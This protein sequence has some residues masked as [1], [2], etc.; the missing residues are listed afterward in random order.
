M[1]EQDRPGIVVKRYGGS[2]LYD[3]AAARYVDSG[4]LAALARDGRRV[5]VRDAATGED[6]T[7]AVLAQ[8]RG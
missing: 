2:R 8:A 6:V 4:D 7:R 3:P 1:P 5:E